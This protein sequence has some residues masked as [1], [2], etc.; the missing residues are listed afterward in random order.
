V[1]MTGNPMSVRGTITEYAYETEANTPIYAGLTEEPRA[2]VRAPGNIREQR[3]PSLGMLALGAEG[4]P[5]WRQ[6]D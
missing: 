3:G 1:T 5:A 4:V 6:K 2:D